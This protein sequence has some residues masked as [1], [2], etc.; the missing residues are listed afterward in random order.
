MK[1]SVAVAFLLQ[2]G[3]E[4]QTDGPNEESTIT[5][6]L[7][8]AEWEFEE[9]SICTGNRGVE[10]M[11]AR[12]NSRNSRKT[13]EI[14]FFMVLSR[15]SRKRVRQTDRQT[16]RESSV[17]LDQNTQKVINEYFL[18]EHYKTMCKFSKD[19]LFN[20]QTNTETAYIK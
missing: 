20:L 12:R 6:R 4:F 11:V 8:L 1:V 5:F 18:T 14:C 2:N 7:A 9:A 13:I 3:K 17:H 16:D 10:K 19:F 15:L